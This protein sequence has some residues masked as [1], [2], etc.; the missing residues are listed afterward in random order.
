MVTRPP[1]TNKYQALKTRLLDKFSETSQSKLNRL[2]R[3]G[4]TAG[5]KPSEILTHMR[6]LA[7]EPG[8]ENIIHTLFLAEMPQSIRP[9]LTV[10]EESDLDK[11]AKVADKMLEATMTPTSTF[12][13]ASDSAPPM[14]NSVNALEQGGTLKDVANSIRSLSQQV[15]SLQDEVKRLKKPPSNRS[16][17]TSRSPGNIQGM[18]ESNSEL[19]YYHQRF[20][21][22]ARKCRNPCSF[23]QTLN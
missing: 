8:N 2:L 5:L 15:N 11:L 13:I 16:S 20:G 3:G 21:T 12:S 10:W 18:T 6:R 4:E 17:G 14:D 7:P 1:V 23:N 22:N 9:T 19:C